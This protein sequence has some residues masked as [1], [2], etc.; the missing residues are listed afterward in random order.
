MSEAHPAH[1]QHHFDSVKQQNE[2]SSLGIW[3]FLAQEIMFFGGLFT[4]YAVYR[5]LYFEAF[6]AAS[7][8]LSIFWGFLNT[9]V[10]IGSSLTMA[11]AVHAAHQ[12]DRA[13][14]R[15]WI[16]ATMVLGTVFLG[17]KVI[18]YSAKFEHHRVPGYN[19]DWFAGGHHETVRNPQPGPEPYSID[20]APAV[21]RFA[22][23]TQIYYSFYFAMTGVHALHMI[24]GIGVMIWLLRKNAKGHFK[25][26]YY[27]PVENTGLYWHL[28]DIVWIFL[29]PL[30]YLI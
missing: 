11:L 1:L 21:V 30:L 15:K 4:G 29:F 17:V 8:E 9:L 16:W 22:R 2:S 10:L 25:D 7:H 27:T 6:Q 12:S 23:Q 5:H 28:V 24:I 18:E 26:G 3:L 14:I 20:G 19:Y 13:G